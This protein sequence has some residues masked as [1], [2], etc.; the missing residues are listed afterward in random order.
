MKHEAASGSMYDGSV[1]WTRLVQVQAYVQDV[2]VHARTS[3]R[4]MLVQAEHRKYLEVPRPVGALFPLSAIAPVVWHG[5]L[6]FWEV[7]LVGS[8]LAR[9]V[10]PTSA[11]AAREHANSKRLLFLP[12]SG[13]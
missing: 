13:P 12:N 8:L 6:V 10:T 5:T 1:V 9:S 2:L 11:K 3:S 7:E 4:Y